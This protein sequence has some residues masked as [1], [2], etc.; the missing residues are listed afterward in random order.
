MKLTTSFLV[1]VTLICGPSLAH[2]GDPDNRTGLTPRHDRLQE[3]S[4]TGTAPR[5]DISVRQETYSDTHQNFPP[6]PKLRNPY[7][8]A[9]HDDFPVSGY[10]R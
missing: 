2:A 7:M 10:R 6:Q 1:A 9:D 4:T 5:D 3:R 8:R